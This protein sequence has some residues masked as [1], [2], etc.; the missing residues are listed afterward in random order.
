[1]GWAFAALVTIGPATGARADA[2]E[3]PPRNCPAG[4]LGDACHGGQYCYP[5]TCAGD[6]ECSGGGTCQEVMICVGTIECGGGLDGGSDPVA[7]HEGPCKEGGICD[8]GAS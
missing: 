2:V 7:T 3:G 6:G 8:E 4:S 1:M 5:V